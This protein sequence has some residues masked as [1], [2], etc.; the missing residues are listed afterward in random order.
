M[1][2][3][4]YREFASEKEI[5]YIKKL[6]GLLKG[7]SANIVS[8]A[9]QGGGIAELLNKI[10]PLLSDFDF[11]LRRVTLELDKN[12]LEICDKF[13]KG[14][15]DP[16]TDITPEDL[17]DFLKYSASVAA[18]I[19]KPADLLFTHDHHPITAVQNKNF[20][21][22]V[23]RCHIDTS[24]PEPTLWNFLRTYVNKYD[25]AIF[26]FHSF[27]GDISVP[28][29]S[30]MPSIDPLSDKNKFLPDEYVDSVFKK[31]NIPR[32]KPVILQVGRFDVLKDPL[33]VVEVFKEVRKSYDCTLILAGG[34][35]TEYTLTDTIYR[36]TLSAAAGVP[37]AHALLLEHNDLEINALQR[38]ADIILQKSLRESFGLAITEALWKK[39]AVVATETGG[40]PLQI[41]E[42]HTGLLCVSNK[43]CVT[44]I[45]KFLQNP[46]LR[47]ALGAAGHRHVRENFIV[48][49]HIRDLL[50]VF[51]KVLGLEF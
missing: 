11:D 29:F 40:V 50:I 45:K 38:G 26:S 33:G 44:Q 10:L 43:S 14:M 3:D 25:A 28:K 9:N 36:E 27:S 34:R 24:H 47:R 42:G 16:T 22:S 15:G 6:G 7:R 51:C 21:K 12:F 17:R 49:R 23:W 48:T 32:S 35:S 46:E 2:I 41:I 8:A 20:Y 31:Y 4:N 1:K 13:Y 37:D 39:K 18:Q 19:T 30:V 5:E